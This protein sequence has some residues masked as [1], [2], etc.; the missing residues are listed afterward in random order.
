MR[1]YSGRQEENN[2]LLLDE[3]LEYGLK[4]HGIYNNALHQ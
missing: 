4:A 2:Q 3:T 1:E